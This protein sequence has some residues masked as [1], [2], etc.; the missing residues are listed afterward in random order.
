VPA[1][2]CFSGN[3]QLALQKQFHHYDETL[4]QLQRERIA[5]RIAQRQVPEGLAGGKVGNY[6]DLALLQHECTKK[7]RHI[8]LRQLVHRAGNA[9]VALKPCFMMGPMSVAQYLAPGQ[10]EF[11]LVVMDEASQMKPRD[12]LGAIARGKQLV[13]VGDPKQL[14]PTSFFDRFIDDDEEATTAIEDSESILK[15]AIPIFDKRRL[16]WH[17]RSQH[18]QLIAFSNHAF[19]EGEL[20]I[21]PS[22][23]NKSDDER[24]EALT[25][26]SLPEALDLRGELCH[27]DLTV[28]RPELPETPENQRLL[29]PAMLEALLEFTPMTKSEFVELIP[30]YLRQATNAH[31]GQYLDQVLLIIEEAEPLSAARQ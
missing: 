23:H 27:F 2:A 22:P 31:E 17:Y 8:P 13:I 12:A 6:T 30:S 16:R 9:L 10:I 20:V 25:E 7:K 29:R 18:E 5:W 21:F 3:A 28:I 1:L 15:T 24:R 4:K 14:P 26:R 11:D 19:Y